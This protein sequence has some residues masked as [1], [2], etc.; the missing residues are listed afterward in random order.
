MNFHHSYTVCVIIDLLPEQTYLLGRLHY[1]L[2]DTSYVNSSHFL[3]VDKT[4]DS[5]TSSKIEKFCLENEIEYVRFNE[6]AG[7]NASSCVHNYAAQYAKTRYIFFSDINLIPPAGFYIRLLKQIEEQR[8]EGNSGR[9][10]VVPVC[11]FAGSINVE[12]I[13]Y[14]CDSELRYLQNL[15]ADHLRQ[16]IY[17]NHCLYDRLYFLARGGERKE[18]ELSP[19][20]VL[21]LNSRI[22]LLSDQFEAPDY[23]YT[24]VNKQNCSHNLS[25]W[26]D[27]STL[28]AKDSLMKGLVLFRVEADTEFEQADQSIYRYFDYLQSFL[29]Y[30]DEPR[31]L[32]DL[33]QGKTAIVRQNAFTTNRYLH[34]FLGIVEYFDLTEFS[35]ARDAFKAIKHNGVSQVLFHN[36]YA[37]KTTQELYDICRCEEFPYIIAERGALNK[38]IFYDPNGFLIDSSSYDE[39]HWNKDIGEA[40]EAKVREYIASDTSFPTM[41]EPQGERKTLEVVR[42]ELN[43]NDSVRTLL[44]CFQRPQDTVTEKDNFIGSFG[45]YKEFETEISRFTHQTK[46]KIRFLYKIHPMENSC[47]DISGDNVSSYHLYDLLPLV[48]GIVC[49]NSGVGLQS[50]LFNKPAFL[51]GNAFYSHPE[52]NVSIKNKSEMDKLC[53]NFQVNTKLSFRFLYYLIEEFYSFGDMETEKRTKEDGSYITAT[54]NIAFETL[55]WIGG[56]KINLR[57]PAGGKPEHRRYRNFAEANLKRDLVRFRKYL[58]LKFLCF[59]LSFW[60]GDWLTQVKHKAMLL[61]PNEA[62]MQMLGRY[63]KYRVSRFLLYFRSILP[64]KLVTRLENRMAKNAPGR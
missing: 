33:N 55:T 60:R 2:A 41:L 3:Y 37:D 54:Y 51:F 46:G 62:T 31:C 8:L 35:D 26:Q 11:D 48:D 13:D 12:L 10:I 42:E 19:F 58:F 18:P 59:L 28:Y 4:V 1:P 34:A 14:A 64:R 47:P 39:V 40:G 7:K 45:T 38:S 15:D 44:I 53:E 17:K 21:E 20:S 32:A 61:K 36:P 29:S 50:L 27:L 16:N 23:V 63:N 30:G 24:D 9:C 43:I 6:Q 49:F 5:E 57:A 22:M 25:D 52:L 56:Q